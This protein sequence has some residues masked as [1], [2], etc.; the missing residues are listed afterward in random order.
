MGVGV[1]VC[2]HVCLF[3]FVCAVCVHVSDCTSQICTHGL[4]IHSVFDVFAACMCLNAIII[5]FLLYIVVSYLHVCADWVAF[6]G[7]VGGGGWLK[8]GIPPPP[9]NFQIYIIIYKT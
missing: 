1:G 6:M 7:G 8:G 9:P 3:F 4:T 5:P 2:L